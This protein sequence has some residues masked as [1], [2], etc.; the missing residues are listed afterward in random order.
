M[1]VSASPTDTFSRQTVASLAAA[2]ACIVA[3]GIGLSLSIPLLSFA[4]DQMGA[5]RTLIGLNTAM[6]GVAT[7]AC[8]PFIA[9]WAR[10]Y[11]MRPVLAAAIALGVVSLLA[12]QAAGPIWVWFPLRF[13]FGVALA[14]LFVL[15][16][17]WINAAAPED[18]RGLVLGVYATALS[19]GFA[20]GPQILALV[21]TSGPAPYFAGAALFALAALPVAIAGGMAPAIEERPS[22]GVVTFLWAA[23]AGTLA[24]LAFGAAETG[25]MALL[26]LYGT[27]IGLDA[28]GAVSLIT[29]FVLGNVLFQIPMGLIADRMD[30]RWVLLFCASVGAG[31]MIVMTL[32]PLSTIGLMALLFV[33]GGIV[34]GMYTV[35]LAHLGSRFRGA[36]LAQANA[37]FVVMY[38][39]GL[40]VGPPLAGA[41]M[42][43]MPP[44]GLPVTLAALFLAYLV[45]VVGRMIALR[46]AV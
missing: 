29:A 31:G 26:P 21:G 36:D 27:A 44:H 2:V 28:M 25:A 43:L 1:T 18:R 20:T 41:G 30:R 24:A 42:D 35:G 14:V 33:W 34:A 46:K 9:G 4:L 38:S 39:I 12:F 15:S 11:G 7:I 5:S 23:P 10:R 16:E 19:I 17:Y 32:V 3:V 13:L 6:G 40:I 22:S 8:A 37:A 45:V